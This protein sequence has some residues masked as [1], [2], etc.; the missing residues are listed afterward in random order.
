MVTQQVTRTGTQ[1]SEGPA[2][3]DKG[4]EQV[5]KPRNHGAGRTSPLPLLVTAFRVLLTSSLATNGQALVPSPRELGRARHL[6]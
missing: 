1:V 2:I 4:G 5:P 6:G 3:W